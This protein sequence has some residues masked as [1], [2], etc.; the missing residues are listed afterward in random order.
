MRTGRWVVLV[1]LAATVALA[2]ALFVAA[3]DDDATDESTAP[4]TQPTAPGTTSPGSTVPA[5][6][7][8]STVIWPFAGSTVRPT[9]PVDAAREFATAYLGFDDPVVG[10]FQQGDNRS[11]EVEVRPR[12]SGPVTTV[13]VRRLTGDD[14]WSVLGAA[15]S[16]IDVTE[17]SAGADL[18]SP[19]HVSGR[20]HTFEGTVIVEVRQDGS[21]GPI[22]RGV[23]TGGGDAMRPFEGQIPF[24]TAGSPHG[25]V[26]FFTE[27]AESGA[28]WEAAAVPVRLRSPDT[29]AR[30]CGDYLSPRHQPGASEM[31][32]TVYFNCD[33]RGG[34]GVAPFPVHRVVE[35]SRAV[36]R[37]S[38]TALLAGPTRE[39]R[40][41]SISS[42]FSAATA[43]LLRS[44]TVGAGGHAIVDFDARL[45]SVI[46]GAS[47]S[48][49]S[50]VLL[51]QLDATV[52]RFRTVESV[53]YR[54]D[55]DCAAFN[56]WLQGGGCEPRTR[57][58]ATD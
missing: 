53:E 13:M 28:V 18:A 6:G 7:D 27:S 48:F 45:S 43:G 20:A 29:D 38:L 35:R 52:L 44:V 22:G 25:A 47:T 14:A 16:N 1:A 36:L 34:T 17:P 49:G 4:T 12:A 21:S 31:E 50:A 24:E 40:D 33:E 19:A 3:G 15:T 32:I 9:D 26:V 11:G 46:P 39:E 58:T 8:R 54:L 10:D 5:G 42:W 41:A 37:A 23:V 30:A 56:E 2:A 57:G 51:S 55:G